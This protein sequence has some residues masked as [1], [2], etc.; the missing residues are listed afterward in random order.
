MTGSTHLHVIDDKL[1]EP[2]RHDVPGLLV[3]PIAN[4]GHL[5]LTS[6]SPSHR[7]V[8]TLRFAPAWLGGL[9][10]REKEEGQKYKDEI[11]TQVSGEQG[12]HAKNVVIIFLVL[13]V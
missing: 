6:K 13:F 5:S 2:I 12:E 11:E 7:V 8:N 1:V 9:E 3:A 10:G 4:A